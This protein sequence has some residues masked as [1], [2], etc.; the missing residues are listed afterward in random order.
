MDA[1]A[2]EQAAFLLAS[3]SIERT[4]S[5]EPALTGAYRLALINGRPY[6][7]DNI[8]DAVLFFG[9]FKTFTIKQAGDR[10]FIF[11]KTKS[12]GRRMWNYD[13]KDRLDEKFTTK[14]DNE[15]LLDAPCF[16]SA[17]ASRMRICAI[18]PGDI[19]T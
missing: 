12:E 11:G 16:D 7:P 15:K 5:S 3:L 19:L 4:D 1:Y 18:A 6:D 9:D 14:L 17:G 10:W 13:V 2:A 8:V